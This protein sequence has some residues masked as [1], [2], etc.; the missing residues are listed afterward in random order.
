MPDWQTS[1]PEEQGLD[2]AKLAGLAEEID[3]REIE[4]HSFLVVRNG[5]IVS[6][7]YFDGWTAEQRHQIQSAARSITSILF[8]IAIDQGYVD[9]VDQKVVD[10]F[11]GRKIQNL[12]ARKQAMTIEDVLT[13]R[14]GMQWQETDTE[15]NAFQGSRDW[16]QALLDRPMATEPGKEWLY[17]S[18][19]S[20]L[21]TAIMSAT[22][23]VNPR[24][25][26]EENLFGPLGIRNVKWMAAPDGIPYGAGGYELTPREMAKIGY[27]YLRNGEWNGKQ[28][29][30]PQWVKKST[31]GYAPI[32]EHFDY[33]YHW[34]I[35][36]SLGGY[37]AYA[38]LG[39]GQQNIVVIPG[40]DMIIVTT[41]MTN[42]SVFE[43][44]EKYVM[45]AIQDC[46]E[47][48]PAH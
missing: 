38:A 15:R 9:N 30:S 22:S 28:L 41:A 4:V 31:T 7:N 37:P 24:D 3:R 34:G 33:G 44:M 36:K 1:T 40:A 32:D 20:H 17:C 26:A 12:D 42:Q 27:L 16:T 45:P 11:P 25:F 5:Y 39:G 18:I 14:L 21:L 47:C 13:M 35:V 46:P 43:L 10:F 29:V 48:N 8:G 23:G 2:S 6:E 19:C